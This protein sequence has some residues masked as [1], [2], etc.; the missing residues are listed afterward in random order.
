MGWVMIS[1][2]HGAKC[3]L[4][5][6]RSVMLKGEYYHFNRDTINYNYLILN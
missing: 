1:V 4:F 2:K 3:I 5:K 6:L